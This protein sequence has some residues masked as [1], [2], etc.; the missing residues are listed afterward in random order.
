M[1]AFAGILGFR[2]TTLPLKYLR[3]LI[4][5]RK[6]LKDLVMREIWCLDLRRD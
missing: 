4:R 2:V 6:K 5:V 1:E 3:L